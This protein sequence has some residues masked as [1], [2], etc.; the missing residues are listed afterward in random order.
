[1]ITFFSIHSVKSSFGYKPSGQFSR[2][3][4]SSAD[5]VS[6]PPGHI[7]IVNVAA[8]R[9]DPSLQ[10]EHSL[11][12]AASAEPAGH[13]TVVDC[14]ST[15]SDVSSATTSSASSASS[16]TSSG[17]AGIG[18]HAVLSA[19]AT[20]PSGHSVRPTISSFDGVNSPPG[21]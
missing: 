1:M 8:I 3:T 5:G 10:N 16:V 14:G 19:V 2:P 7:D 13:I 11:E 9:M 6:F 20:C 17:S 4:I 18:S 12:P 15:S 21:Q